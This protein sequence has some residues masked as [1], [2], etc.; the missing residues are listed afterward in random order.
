[1]AIRK[2]LKE[3]QQQPPILLAIVI[4]GKL[5]MLSRNANRMVG[6]N[7]GNIMMQLK[8]K[9]NGDNNCATKNKK[10]T[11]DSN[12]GNTIGRRDKKQQ[13]L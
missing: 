7:Y 5:L 3:R 6:R 4:I 8:V 1:M 10:K 12:G 9:R 13:H 2:K 11:I